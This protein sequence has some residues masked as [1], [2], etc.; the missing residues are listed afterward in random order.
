[1][2]TDELSEETYRAVLITAENFN[3]N[4]TL[5]FGVLASVCND[6]NDYLQKAKQLIKKWRT[7]LPGSIDEIFFDVKKPEISSFENVLAEL[8]GEF[9]KLCK[10][11]VS[12][13]KF[14]F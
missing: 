13:R 2:D 8:E 5:Q 9:E 7:D 1:M 6:D 3:H 10:I 4:L 12:S 14:E 11:P